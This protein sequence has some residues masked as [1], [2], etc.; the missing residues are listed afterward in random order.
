MDIKHIIKRIAHGASFIIFLYALFGFNRFEPISA[1][2]ES[3]IALWQI[4][5]VLISILIEL[6]IIAAKE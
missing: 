6:G 4:K 2:Q 5:W 1:I 3:T